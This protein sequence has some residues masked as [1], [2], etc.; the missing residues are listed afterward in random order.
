ML[1]HIMKVKKHD[2]MLM[3]SKF[4]NIIHVM[5][6]TPTRTNTITKLEKKRRK[7]GRR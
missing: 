7:G 2:L 3:D 5:K 6:I 4:K 1:S